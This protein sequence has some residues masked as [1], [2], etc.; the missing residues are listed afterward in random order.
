MEWADDKPTR[1]LGRF[2]VRWS[3]SVDPETRAHAGTH[4]RL[5]HENLLLFV[6]FHCFRLLLSSLSGRAH[7]NRASYW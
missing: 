5:D 4:T 1:L 7:K 2:I 6:L 3:T